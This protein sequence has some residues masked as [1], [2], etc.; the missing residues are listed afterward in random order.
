MI[1]SQTLDAERVY[2]RRWWAF[3]VLALAILIVVI[4][5]TIINVALPT[6][7][8]E[9]GATVSDLQWIVDA[10]ILAFAML[11]L[12]MGTLSD[13]IGRATMLRAGMAVFGI[14]SLAAV[15]ASSAW[16]L[17]SARVF[18]GIGASMIM[19]ATLAIITNIF[20][21]EERGK[22]IGI[23]GAMNGVGVALGP[24]LG[25][26]LIQHFNWSAIFFINVPIVA[27]ALVAGQFLVPNSQ[28]PMPR[29]L[30][31]PG[32]ILSALTLSVLVFSLIKGSDWGWTHPAIIGSFASA[33]VLGVVFI[34]WERKAT[35]PMLDLRL[36]RNPCLSTGA[37]GIAIMA[38]TMFGVL[39]ALTMYMQFVKDYSPLETGIRFL[40][41][42]FGYAFGS[43]LSNRFVR[44][45]GTK[46]VVV[47]GFLGMAVGAVMI[48]FWRIDTP[49]WQIGVLLLALSFSLSNIMT[50]CLNAV[51][52]A[53]PAARAGV[54][55]AISTVSLQLGGA[56][57]VAALGSALSSVYRTKME[58]M[59][60]SIP[61]IPIQ[62]SD[63]VAESIGSLVR[64]I[65]MLPESIRGYITLLARQSFMEGWQVVLLVITAIG[66]TS[67]SLALK[68]M[69]QLAAKQEKG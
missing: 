25:G 7:Q 41:I 19:P 1:K 52:G 29:R 13:R 54:G 55:S 62:L 36:F 43:V 66:L 37:S 24:L 56:L 64:I 34:L 21:D 16:Q 20:P 27:A 42:A 6:I 40:P 32:T 65:S 15:F 39:F 47:A 4:D 35:A 26:I 5:H 12:T 30:D 69:P 28:D 3:S 8:R 23:W 38:V 53:V 45:W 48:A 18:M 44:L 60:T 46:Y 67:A 33:V 22:A 57:G 59:L 10:Y 49:Y 61:S 31:I 14:A 11:L 17:V 51:L 2:E 63:A 50:P 9:L 68:F 58:Y